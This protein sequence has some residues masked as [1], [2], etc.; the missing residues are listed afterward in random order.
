MFFLGTLWP[1][2]KRLVRGDSQRLRNIFFW[3]YCGGIF[4]VSI[5]YN[6]TQR[7]ER[8]IEMEERLKK[9]LDELNGL[10]PDSDLYKE[11]AAAVLQRIDPHKPFGTLLY[12]TIARL[13]WN[14]FFEAVALRRGS[15][16]SDEIEVYLRKRTDDDT[17]Y[18]G[19]WHAPGSVFRPGENERMVADRVSREFGVPIY[20][21]TY[22]GEY[23]D[24]ERGEV[25]GS[26][27]SRIYLVQLSGSPRVDDRHG[28][29]PV[30]K[31]PEVT[32]DS[33]QIGIIPKAVSSFKQLP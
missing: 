14:Q 19:E 3:N 4:S 8:R 25:R 9:M 5:D 27:V 20:D 10:S 24:W 33:H 23:V 1:K 6:S 11:F 21:F 32:V 26:G 30:D 18:P 17:A 13:S 29:F 12:N 2:E 15:R 7:K 16:P 31:L 28:W 22:I